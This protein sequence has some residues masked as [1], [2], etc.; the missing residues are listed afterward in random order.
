MGLSRVAGLRCG[1]KC[2]FVGRAASTLLRSAPSAQIRIINLH[3]LIEH[4]ALFALVHRLENFVLHEPRG[5]VGN[6]YLPLVFER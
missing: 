6:T 5:W 3:A 2:H 4:A 1:E